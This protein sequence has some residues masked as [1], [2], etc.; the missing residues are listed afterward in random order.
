MPVGTSDSASVLLAGLAAVG[1]DGVAYFNVFRAYDLVSGVGVF[2][3]SGG[4]VEGDFCPVFAARVGVVAIKGADLFVGLEV[5]H[6]ITRLAAVSCGVGG[7]GLYV[8]YG[9][10]V[11]FLVTY[12]VTLVDGA[13]PGGGGGEGD[14]GGC[15][16][17][18]GEEIFHVGFVFLFRFLN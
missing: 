9:A 12:A 14:S 18:C 8:A 11:P 1:V 6:G 15:C 13:C 4:V 7:S 5:E 3:C 2:T 17:C 16:G 10:G